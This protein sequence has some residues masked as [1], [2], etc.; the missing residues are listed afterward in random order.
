MSIENYVVVYVSLENI[1]S[2]HKKVKDSKK[3]FTVDW[4]QSVIVPQI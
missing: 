1:D 2:S 3:V 4:K